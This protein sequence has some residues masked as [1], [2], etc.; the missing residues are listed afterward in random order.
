MDEELETEEVKEESEG[1]A[2]EEVEESDTESTEEENE[3]AEEESEHEE[4]VPY[5]RFSEVNESNKVLQKA[6][7]LVSSRVAPKQEDE[8]E[9]EVDEDTK[10]AIEFYRNKDR[11][12][13]ETAIGR[14]FEETDELKA[15]IKIPG[16]SDPKSKIAEKIE[17][18]R[19]QAASQNQFMNREQAYT[20][21]VGS[22]AIKPAKKQPVIEKKKTKVVTESKSM[23]SAAAKGS[24]SKNTSVEKRLEGKSF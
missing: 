21:L 8:P 13:Y 9:P 12:Q 18:V 17:Q 24:A 5:A 10:K 3:E 4:S 20:Y 2:T 1:G 23:A 19:R 16:Y 6:L 22:G 7:E 11:K 15:S 14:M